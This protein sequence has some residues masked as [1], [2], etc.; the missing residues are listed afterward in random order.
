NTCGNG[1]R[2][3]GEACDDGNTTPN[4][5]CDATCKSTEP[6]IPSFA[7]G[8]FTPGCSTAGPSAR[9]SAS[10]LLGGFLLLGLALRRRR[11]T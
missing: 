9:P 1:K 11:A 7:G 4:D 3:T 5:G 8:G 10:F 6:A 2:E